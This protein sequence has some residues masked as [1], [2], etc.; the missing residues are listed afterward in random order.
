MHMRVAQRISN[1]RVPSGSVAIWWL[2]QNS[3]LLQGPSTVTMVD[4]FFSRL[5]PREKYIHDEAPLRADEIGPDAVFCTHNHS[6]HTDPGFLSALARHWPA[7]LFFGPPESANKMM[8]SGIP[9]DRITAVQVGDVV[10]IGE[11]SAQVVSSK[12]P[13][14]SD[15]AHYGYVLEMGGA[16]KVY[17]T[18][19]IMRGVT[20]EPTLMEPLRR[21]A[22]EVALV[23]TSPTEE[24]FPDFPEAAAL[25]RAIGARVVIPAHYDCFAKRTFDPAAFAAQFGKR[26]TL[27]S[28]IIPYCGVYQHPPAPAD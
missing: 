5:G 17:N 20:C 27:R 4:P 6:D 19:D 2:G 1:Q 28:V 24:E 14:V 22:P 15:V 8:E 23:T 7:A 25:A 18:G 13:H 9:A 16:P 11:A 10:C 21:A 26:D 3:Y 12:T